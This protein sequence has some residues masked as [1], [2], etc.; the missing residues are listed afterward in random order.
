MRYE[1]SC[2]LTLYI[3][4]SDPDATVEEVREAALHVLKWRLQDRTEV[5]EVV[6]DH[7]STWVD[8]EPRP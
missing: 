1:C 3:T 8:A 4:P 2:A 5:P 7:D 6:Y